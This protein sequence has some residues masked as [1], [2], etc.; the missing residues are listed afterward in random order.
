MFPSPLT[1]CFIYAIRGDSPEKIHSKDAELQQKHTHNS[2]ANSDII[3]MRSSKN[4]GLKK[5]A[6]F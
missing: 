1:I 3:A 5:R 6:V 4:T 2:H